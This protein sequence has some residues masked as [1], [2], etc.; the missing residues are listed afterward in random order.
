MNCLNN[1]LAIEK[2][3]HER[4]DKMTHLESHKKQTVALKIFEYLKPF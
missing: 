3:P 2:H 4:K 1:K